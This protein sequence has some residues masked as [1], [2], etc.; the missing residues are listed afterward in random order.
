MSAIGNYVHYFN[1]NYLKYGTGY[2]REA[3]EPRIASVQAQKAKNLQRTSNLGSAGVTEGALAELAKRIKNENLQKQAMEIAKNKIK[4]A[5]VESDI[6]VLIRDVLMEKVGS[7]FDNGAGGNSQVSNYTFNANDFTLDSGTVNLKEAANAKKKLYENIDRLNTNL[8]KT[9]YKFKK[10]NDGTIQTIQTINRNFNE[11]FSKL[12]VNAANNDLASYFNIT[13]DQG[14]L[15]ALHNFLL[16]VQYSTVVSALNGAFGEALVAMADDGIYNLAIETMNDTLLEEIDKKII[17]NTT[18]RFS[19]DNSKVSESVQKAIKAQNNVNLYEAHSSQ[20]KV[21]ASITITDS[22]GIESDINA[23]VKA[24]TSKGNASYYT[25]HLQ[26]V[27]LF[28]S[29]STTEAQFGNHWLNLHV[30]NGRGSD[31]AMEDSLKQHI[32]YEALV[33]GN[34][35]K[36]GV[37]AA[38]VFVSIDLNTGKVYAKNTAEMLKNNL[39][40]IQIYPNPATIKLANEWED[41]SWEQRIANLVAQV[42]GTKMYVSYKIMLKE[43]A[44]V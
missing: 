16:Q 22:Q 20:N 15:T 28:Y 40:D 44:T 29:L 37:N 27:D 9:G 3:C 21:D 12:G 2:A 34:L 14:C 43:V 1:K 41:V 35:L 5:K 4:V 39:E 23:S 18:A 42:H 33:S 11:F 32:A 13:A 19:A 38:N 7:S 30:A 8:G 31:A 36:T 26:D 24:Y 10:T 17:G 6:S 25:P